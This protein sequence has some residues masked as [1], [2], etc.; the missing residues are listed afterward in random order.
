MK[1][2]LHPAVF[3][4]RDGVLNRA[5]VREGKPYPP[6]GLDEL[7]ILPGTMEALEALA[8]AGYL[9]VGITN[10]PDVARGTQRREVV[11]AINRALLADLPLVD[12]LVCYHDDWDECDCRKPKPGLLLEAAAHHSLDLPSSFLIGDRWKDMEAGRRAGCRTVLIDYGYP[13]TGPDTRLD[14]KAASLPEAAAWILSQ[15]NLG[16]GGG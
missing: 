8:A 16:G 11:E 4:D 5:V 15:T 13:E 6:A 12:I 1:N 7:Q 2:Q 10:Q 14:H 3:L 9:L